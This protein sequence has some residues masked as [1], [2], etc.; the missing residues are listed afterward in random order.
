MGYYVANEY[1]E[2]ELRETPPEQ[3]IVEKC[4]ISRMLVCTHS[5]SNTRHHRLWRNILA[6]KPRVTRFPVE[7]DIPASALD[8]TDAGQA[9]DAAMVGPETV[10]QN[11]NVPVEGS[12]MAVDGNRVPEAFPAAN[13]MAAEE[14]NLAQ[15]YTETMAE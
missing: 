2:E 10:Y 4:V 9:G 12:M 6:D 3:P 11:E 13:K 8:I 15:Q 1:E 14:T 5:L 7:F